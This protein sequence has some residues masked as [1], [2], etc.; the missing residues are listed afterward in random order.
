MQDP[1]GNVCGFHEY[2]QGRQ[3]DGEGGYTE[4]PSTGEEHLAKS[5]HFFC[6]VGGGRTGRHVFH[7]LR[8]PFYGATAAGC[9]SCSVAPA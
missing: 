4:C 8:I 2:P 3:Q 5:F 1:Y 6:L 7:R 9:C